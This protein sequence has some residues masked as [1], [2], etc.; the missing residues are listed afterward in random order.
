M[1]EINFFWGTSWVLD[2]F[3]RGCGS[4]SLEHPPPSGHVKITS[5]MF[6]DALRPRSQTPKPVL[7][8]RFR[9]PP[10]KK[11]KN[12]IKKDSRTFWTLSQKKPSSAHIASLT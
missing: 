2:L 10:Q 3:V 8:C 4:I 6:D 12:K 7:G 11:N 9:A 5:D 1:L